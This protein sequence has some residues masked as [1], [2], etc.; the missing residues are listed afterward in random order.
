MNFLSLHK[1]AP[2][3]RFSSEFQPPAWV[4]P[5]FLL[6]VT[7]ALFWS[8]LSPSGTLVLSKAG[9]DLTGQF[10]WWRQ[11][12][13]DQLKQGHLALWNPHLFC[14]EPF[15]GGFQSALLYPPNWL[16]M[17]LPLPFALNFSIALHVFL[18]GWF[19]YLWISA[20]GSHFASAVL[21]AFMFMFGASYILHLVPGHLPN[22][23]TMAWIPLVFLCI[24]QLGKEVR[25]KWIL[26]GMAVLTLQ[27]FSGHIQYVYYTGVVS[28]V[29]VLFSLPPGREKKL[30]FLAGLGGLYLGAALL[31]A[32]QLLAGWEAMT[33]SA[34]AQVMDIDFLDIA[35]ITPE[36]LWCLFMPDFFGG[37]QSYWG[38]GLYQ[39]GGIFVSVTAFILVLFALKVSVHPQK[40]FF[41][42]LGLFLTLLAVGKRTPLFALFCKYFPLFARF[43]GVGK[44]NIFITLCLV[45]LAV[46]GMDEIFRG[47]ESLKKLSK[48]IFYGSGFFFFA[49]VLF[50]LLLHINGGHRFGPFLPHAGEMIQSLLKCGITLGSLALLAF[51]SF[52]RPFFRYG[53]LILAMGE[54]L[55]FA[56]ANRP[57]FDWNLLN[58]QAAAIQNRYDQ[59]PGDYRVFAGSSNE[60]LGTSGGSVWGDDPFVPLRYDRFSVLTKTM[61]TH[62]HNFKQPLADYSR[63][64]GLTRLQYA[65]YE[66][67]GALVSQKLD[68]APMPRALLVNHWQI[69]SLESIWPEVLNPHFDFRKTVWL[70][71]DPALESVS[72]SVKG[73][74]SLKDISTDKLEIQAKLFSPAVLVLSDNYS[75]G[76]KVAGLADSVQKSYAVLPANGFQMAVPLPAGANHFILEYRPA[77]FVIGEWISIFA[78]F[79]FLGAVFLVFWRGNKPAQTRIRLL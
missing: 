36:R 5:C 55:V 65:F 68:M 38:G 77:A 33:E 18:A 19:T 14:G 64:L 42:G 49:A 67:D 9:E 76:W 58:R 24:D 72:D 46:M 75:Q 11:F 48:G 79:F 27:I 69:R 51:F 10:V 71:S 28:A 54:L 8:F 62:V 23:C 50:T 43:R 25:A 63:A 31:S 78:W 73:S 59:N 13:F 30:R 7:A 4:L 6:F 53:F 40:K 74:V 29:Y 44:L 47:H 15:F 39:E 52:N 17:I 34:R 2:A 66:K 37:W 57:F 16:F 60:A 12:G 70:E 20:R 26:L 22:L 56:A 21:A 3:D 1:R 61:R 32:V 45:A 41:A 35:D